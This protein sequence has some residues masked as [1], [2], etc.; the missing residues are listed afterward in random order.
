MLAFWLEL[1]RR[2]RGRR[3]CQSRKIVNDGYGGTRLRCVLERDHERTGRTAFERQH[4]APL[5]SDVRFWP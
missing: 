4:R 3:R 1:K 5:G 2:P